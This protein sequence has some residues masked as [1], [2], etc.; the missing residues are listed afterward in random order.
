MTTQAQET[1]STTTP[2]QDLVGCGSRLTMFLGPFVGSGMGDGFGVYDYD[3]YDDYYFY[4]EDKYA[5]YEDVYLW[6]FMISPPLRNVILSK[7]ADEVFTSMASSLMGFVK[8]MPMRTTLGVLTKALKY[9]KKGLE[10]G[11]M[12]PLVNMLSQAKALMTMPE[13]EMKSLMDVL[14]ARLLGDDIWS[15]MQELLDLLVENFYAGILALGRN[16]GLIKA[17]C[18]I[19][20]GRGATPFVCATSHYLWQFQYWVDF[21]EWDHEVGIFIGQKN[22]KQAK[23][24][25]KKLD[26]FLTNQEQGLF[27]AAVNLTREV[28]SWVLDLLFGDNLDEAIIPLVDQAASLSKQLLLS[29]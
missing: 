24:K 11:A 26:E 25:M 21:L 4:Y 3:S 22:I 27:C 8:S 18:E 16:E 5:D 2:G 9:L 29:C 6:F 13:E 10:A 17:D 20:R 19:D 7:D 28:S 14:A 15:K 1:I 23:M 12:E